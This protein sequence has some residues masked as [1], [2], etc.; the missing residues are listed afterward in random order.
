LQ[1][2]FDFNFNYPFTFLKG[3][4][5]MNFI[6][7]TKSGRTLL[8]SAVLF[9]IIGT[10]AVFAQSEG[11]YYLEI[12]DVSQA[13]INSLNE[14]KK[15]EDPNTGVGEDYYFLARTANGTSL[16]SKDKGLTLEQVRQKLTDIA[17]RNTNYVKSIDE[18]MPLTQQYWGWCGWGFSTGTPRIFYWINRLE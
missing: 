10:G 11:K 13:T 16:H 12:Y 18:R 5:S 9:A 8:L 1:V 3:E 17:P 7:F 15:K 6:T 14:M 2:D 4:Y